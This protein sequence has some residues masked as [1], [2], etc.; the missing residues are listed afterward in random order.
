MG[1]NAKEPC[2]HGG[3]LLS[4]LHPQELVTSVS[5]QGTQ[6]LMGDTAQGAEMHPSIHCWASG[7]EKQ[8]VSLNGFQQGIAPAVYF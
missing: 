3:R 7:S 2:Q 5:D 4:P 6:P 1:G 8:W